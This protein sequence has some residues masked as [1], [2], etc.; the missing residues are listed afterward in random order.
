M[1]GH[2]ERFLG[3]IVVAR[4]TG[5]GGILVATIVV[6]TKNSIRRRRRE[7]TG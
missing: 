3:D 5:C 4:T 2:V 1:W 7:R 6:C